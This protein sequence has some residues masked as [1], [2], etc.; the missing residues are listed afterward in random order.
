MAAFWLTACGGQISDFVGRN[1]ADESPVPLP[2]DSSF[3][4]DST[5]K[6]SSGSV[7]STGTAVK[8]TMR[9][10]ATNRSLSGS[11][12]DAKLSFQQQRVR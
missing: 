9:L 4:S 2:P 10:T 3:A 1:P 7:R 11:Q 6:L 8:A 12:V 5:L